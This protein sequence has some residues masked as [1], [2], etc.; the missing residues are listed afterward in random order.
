MIEHNRLLTWGEAVSMIS[1]SERSNIVMKLGTSALELCSI[2]SR[3]GWLLG[4]FRDINARW[5]NELNL[6]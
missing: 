1:V 4:E 5:K 3:I 2:V 6:Y